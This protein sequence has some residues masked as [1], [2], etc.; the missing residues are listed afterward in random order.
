MDILKLFEEITKDPYMMH[1][2]QQSE[3]N[4]DSHPGFEVKQGMLLYHGRLVILPQSSSIPWLLEE[5]HCSPTGGHYGFLRTYRRLGESLYWVGM[6][7]SVR[8]FVRAWDV[9]QR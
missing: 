1:V 7:R 9:Y 4:P 3:E 8:D 5:F 2:N 6:Q